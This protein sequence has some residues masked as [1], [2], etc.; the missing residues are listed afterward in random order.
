MMIPAL[1]NGNW[2]AALVNHLWQSTMF[3]GIAWLLTI[4]LRKYPARIRYWVWFVASVKFLL[5]F[6]LLV[7]AG[8]WLRSW[9]PAPPAQPAVASAVEQFA[10]PFAPAQ[11]FDAVSTPVAAHHANWLP[12]VLLAIWA[13]GALLVAARLAR[14]WWIA[15][16]SKRA[17]TPLQ[18][19][20]DIPV[21]CTPAPIEP[22]I[23]GIFRPVL[24]L[25]KGIE[26]RLTKEQF[27]AIVAHEMCHVRRRDNLTYAIHMIVEALFWFHPLAWWIGARLIDERERA[28]DEIVVQAGGKAEAYAEGILSVCKFYVESPLACV[29]GVTGADLKKRVVRI[30]TEQIGRKLTLSRKVLLAA[31]GSMAMATPVVIGLVHARPGRAQ[32]PAATSPV[33]ETIKPMAA[34]ANPGFEVVT[35]KPSQPNRPGKGITVKG[36]HLRTINTDLDDLMVLAYGVHTRQIV[37]APDWADKDLFD[38]DG[39]PDVPGRPNVKQIREMLQKL[40]SDRFQLKFHRETKELSVYVITVANGGPK[41]AKTTASPDNDLPG[42]FLRG[43]GNLAVTNITMKDFADG[44]Q[45]AVMDRPVVDHTGLTDHYDFT[46]KWTPDDSQFAPYRETNPK[47]APPAGDNPNAQP[48]LYTAVQEQLGLRIEAT[49]A[50]DEV[51]VIDHV[52]QPSPN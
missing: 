50:P 33:P 13:C 16:T 31:L 51:M 41:M 36:T 6:S 29:S 2:T 5:P 47:M 45:S 32:S 35:I 9:V 38:L 46:L 21:L 19:A 34:D 43:L 52:E 17:A 15:M 4:S 37:G 14:G 11:M 24:L 22:G 12:V 18:L 48:S 25:P 3:A 27:A 1:W 30:M 28:C 26:Q 8:E 39:V 42:F 40:L 49:K 23:L 44:M 20:A 10:Q 7:T